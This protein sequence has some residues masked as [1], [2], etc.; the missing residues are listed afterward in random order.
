MMSV[1][2]TN[3]YTIVVTFAAIFFELI[4][5]NAIKHILNLYNTVI[6]IVSTRYLYYAY[7]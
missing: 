7:Q 6:I 5:L 4:A 1:Q 2:F 3:V